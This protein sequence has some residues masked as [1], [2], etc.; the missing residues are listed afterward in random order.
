MDIQ[1][2]VRVTHRYAH[3]VGAPPAEVFPLL[4]PV[5][6]RDWIPDWNPRLV[7]SESGVAEE[8]AVFFT[9]VE[10]REATW[11]I[12]EH[13]AASGRIRMVQLVPGLVLID[14]EILVSAAGGGT[15][16]DIVYTYTALS[17]EGEAWVAAR[18][19]EW[20]AGFIS[21][22]NLLNDYFAN[23]PRTEGSESE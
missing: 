1:S 2:P 16:C 5:R 12:T 20:F 6:E 13:D 18:T 11:L 19:P 9:D 14:L 3:R 10:D 15:E 8:G 22:W 7:I 4:C 23:V 17:D 21:E